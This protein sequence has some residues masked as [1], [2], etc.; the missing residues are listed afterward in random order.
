M[1]Q[2]VINAYL[3]APG[4]KTLLLES[5]IRQ[6]VSET[7]SEII[8]PTPKVCPLDLHSSAVALYWTG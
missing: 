8:G 4:L 5:D 7:K 6:P 3:E 2:Y 1:V